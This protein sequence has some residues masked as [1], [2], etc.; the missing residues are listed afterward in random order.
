MKNSEKEKKQ[1]KEESDLEI[2]KNLIDNANVLIQSVDN[3][4]NIIY[5]NKKWKLTL[6]YSQKEIERLKFTDILRKDQVLHC[7]KVFSKLSKVKSL[8]DVETVLVTK[9]GK[10]IPVKGDIGSVKEASNFRFSMGIFHDISKEKLLNE[11]LIK[12]KQIS[13]NATYGIGIADLK[14]NIVY[15]NPYF[16]KIHGYSAKKIIGKNLNIFHDKEQMKKV[17]QINKDVFQKKVCSSIEVWHTHKSG[18]KFP[19]LMS[20]IAINDQKDNPQYLAVTAIDLT[21]SKQAKKSLQSSE[22]K[23]RNLLENLNEGIWVIDNKSFITF[24]N[25]KMTEILGYSKNEMLGKYLFYFMDEKSKKIAKLNIKQKNNIKSQYDFE[26]I[27]KDGSRIF[28]RMGTTPIFDDED[29]YKGAIVELT[30]ITRMRNSE[31]ETEEHIAKLQEAKAEL[32]ETNAKLKE[33]MN[34]L[35]T[36]KEAT[37]DEVLKFKEIEE[38]NEKLKKEL[39]NKRD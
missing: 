12:F 28:A 37:V 32:E 29:I 23:Y 17:F 1:K 2:Y 35:Q 14:G 31:Q 36:F 4:G 19:M 5:V 10:E 25:L 11:E 21:K 7:K 39:K 34:Q 24:V 30:D 18:K 38:E 9:N 20:I 27:K 33:T 8:K 13:D 3:K 16:A 22:K 6:G 26:F 15:V